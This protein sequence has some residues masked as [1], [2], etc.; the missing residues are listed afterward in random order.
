MLWR[1][2]DGW[3]QNS[4]TGWDLTDDCCYQPGGVGSPTGVQCSFVSGDGTGGTE[5]YIG[6]FDNR[7][8]C[9]EAV[10]AHYPVAN[11]ATYSDP[12]T[13][14][15]RGNQRCYAEFSMDS[16]DPSGYGRWI[17]CLFG[18][19]HAMPPPPPAPAATTSGGGGCPAVTCPACPTLNCPSVQ[20]PACPAVT[21]PELASRALAG[22]ATSTLGAESGGDG[23]LRATNTALV[24]VLS[25]LVGVA[26]G[27]GGHA[28][29]V[30]R[31]GRTT[32]MTSSAMMPPLNSPLASAD[33]AAYA[34]PL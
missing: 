19:L 6:D 25:V 31:R 15:D 8:A 23:Q 24:S 1:D 18:G 14:D 27:A 13:T 10:V 26:A 2:P 34:R 16:V 22:G 11:G 33:S 17:T 5:S 7:T 32:P 21:C 29:S 28:L 30:H 4:A 12:L 9:V 3:E 20:C